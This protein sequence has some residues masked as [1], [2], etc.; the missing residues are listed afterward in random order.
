MVADRGNGRLVI[1]T[2]GSTTSVATF[3]SAT[4]ESEA[5]ELDFSSP[6]RV[7][8]TEGTVLVAERRGIIQEFSVTRSQHPSLAR[9]K[10][11]ETPAGASP[12]F[13]TLGSGASS[14]NTLRQ[15]RNLVFAPMLRAKE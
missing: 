8:S 6:S 7:V 1:L 3:D 15:Y 12:A 4:L 2:R 5:L 11:L 14:E 13:P 10:L 9:A